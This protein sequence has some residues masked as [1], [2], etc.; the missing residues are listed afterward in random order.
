MVRTLVGSLLALG[1]FFGSN[2]QAP[3]ASAKEDRLRTITVTG[4]AEAQAVPDI[5]T[6]SIGVDTEAKTP[7]EA[8]ADNAKR[9]TAV[10]DR[11][12]G[13]GIADR[14]LRTRQL[15]IRPIF[16]NRQQPRKTV[17][18]RASNEVTVTIRDIE[19]TGTILDETVADGANSINGP[20]FSIADPE[21]LLIAAREAAVKD[22][23]VK[24][25][26]Y[27]AAADVELGEVISI[28]EK[29]GGAAVPRHMRAQ[30]VAET[31]PIAAGETTIS[32]GVTM[33]FAID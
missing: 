21:P 6:M 30:A 32:A 23:I 8:L 25:E 19:R 2:L 24:A 1:I 5:A 16:A 9:M 15:D 22:A 4:R 26:R 28:D 12:K 10:M 11:L 14:D 31:T 7:G 20:T 18:Y 13:A 29:Q 27:A 33:I 17:G 3:S